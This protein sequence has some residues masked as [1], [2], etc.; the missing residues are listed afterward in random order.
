MSIVSGES[1]SGF[2]DAYL[3]WFKIVVN[4]VKRLISMSQDS[5]WL[6]VGWRGTGRRPHD[7]LLT[8]L[9]CLA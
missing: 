3:T 9:F 6:M 5:L 1:A 4:W 8:W 7:R 2:R